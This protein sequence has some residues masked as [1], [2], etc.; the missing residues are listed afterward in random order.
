MPEQ[1][2]TIDIA[3]QF[4]NQSD[5]EYEWTV[6]NDQDKVVAHGFG[7]TDDIAEQQARDAIKLI[8]SKTRKVKVIV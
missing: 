3:P 1:T 4:W 7:P 8:K 2:F 5:I 6:S